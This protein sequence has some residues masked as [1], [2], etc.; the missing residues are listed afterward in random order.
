MISEMPR[1]CVIYAYIS[2]IPIVYVIP[3]WHKGMTHKSDNLIQI[4]G[5]NND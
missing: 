1:V 2:V 3:V 4:S 5:G